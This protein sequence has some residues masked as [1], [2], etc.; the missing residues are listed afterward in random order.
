MT[1]LPLSLPKRIGSGLRQAWQ[2][3]QP[4]RHAW[5]GAAAG[6]LLAALLFV[7]PA[8]WDDFRG[9]G[10][11]GML[12]GF[13]AFALAGLTAAGL[14]WLG[15]RLAAALPGRFVA[16]AVAA[17][18][19]VALTVIALPPRADPRLLIFGAPAVAAL[20]GAVLWVLARGGWKATAA[21]QRV[22]LVLAG[23]L[24]LAGAAWGGAW[25]LSDGFNSTP[26]PNAAVLSGA[27]IIPLALP[28]PGQ[29]GNYP[30]QT[31]TYGS[32]R[33]LHRPEFGAQAVLITQPVDGSKMVSGWSGLRRDYW[34]FGLEALP[35]NGRVWYPQGEGP[36]PLVLI[37]HGNHIMEYPSDTGYDY[38]GELFASRGLIA[39]SVDE[40][41]LNL[42]PAADMLVLWSL[43]EEDDARAWLLLE[44]LRAWER[45]NATPGN[46]FYRRVDLERIAL[47]GHSRGGEAVAAAAAFNRLPRYPE[48]ASLSFDYNFA[49]RGVAAIAPIDGRYRPRGQALPLEDVSYFVLHGSKDMDATAFEGRRMYGRLQF[50]GADFHFKSALY[51]YGANHGQFNTSWGRKDFVEPGMRL[52]NLRSI[53]APEAQRQVASV[54]LSAFLEAVLHDER[55]YL[56]LFRDTRYAAGWLPDTIYLT[57]Y[58]DSA[59]QA[60]A[61]FEED[62]DLT[63]TT[64]PGG[65]L[66]GQNLVNWHEQRPYARDRS[67]LDTV[68]AYLGWDEQQQTGAAYV[69]RLPAQGLTLGT[70]ST[71]VFAL[72]DASS[73][74]RPQTTPVDLTVEIVDRSGQTARL[75]LSHY[76]LLQPRIPAEILKSARLSSQLPSEVVFQNFEFLLVDFVQANPAL[77]PRALAEVRLVFDRTASGIVALDDVGFR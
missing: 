72:A 27:Q 64:L 18:V 21:G 45:W 3:V 46:P 42:S 77:D 73:P 23:L 29:P 30:V 31:L 39:V 7:L 76:S 75:A 56:P 10:L 53:M 9:T 68:A 40:N 71:L 41:F 52:F 2:A 19:M 69:I 1:G 74:N 48:D 16:A 25:L 58:H 37:V 44:H 17:L 22:V 70:D 43:S 28:D 26:P 14:A 4:G 67:Q 36:F 5:T 38:L 12:V 15:Q 61:T 47:I 62:I 49:I 11:S 65:E 33:D 59:T 66:R 32:G 34:G 50:E 57:Q 54:Y 20:L 6:M 24:G 63:S 51:I 35:L 60:V 8:V 55:G 13:S